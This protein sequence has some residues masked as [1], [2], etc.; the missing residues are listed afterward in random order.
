MKDLLDLLE[1]NLREAV[2]NSAIALQLVTPDDNLETSDETPLWKVKENEDVIK[3]ILDHVHWL[4]RVSPEL[5]L[6]VI[7][8]GQEKLRDV[9][10]DELSDPDFANGTPLKVA[11]NRNNP[12]IVRMPP[13]AIR[14]EQRMKTTHEGYKGTKGD[15]TAHTKELERA[16]CAASY[17][18]DV[19]G[20][21]RDQCANSNLWSE[22]L[23]GEAARQR[24]EHVMTVVR[25][26]EESLEALLAP[27]K[28]DPHGI[29][30]DSKSEADCVIGI[31]H[32]QGS[33][34]LES[35]WRS[36]DEQPSADQPATVG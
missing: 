16:S 31:Q 32:D 28:Y 17:P 21:F 5:L 36:D 23:P 13:E 19:A 24:F 30:S 7:L 1:R 25:P 34:I 6:N 26:R 35:A 33:P 12:D 8:Q 14:G 29:G 10:F 18:N 9:L 20:T 3:A 11:I 4:S 22:E 27:S 2:P 15:S